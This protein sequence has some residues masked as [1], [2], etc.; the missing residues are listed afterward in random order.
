MDRDADRIWEL[1][2]IRAFW[3]EAGPEDL[4]EIHRK[5]RLVLA[6]ERE[7]FAGLWTGDRAVLAPGHRFLA[8]HPE[9]RHGVIVSLHQG[10]YKLIPELYLNEGISP[11][12]LVNNLALEK[13]RPDFEV[14]AD[15][16]G[17]KTPITWI[18]VG[19]PRFAM[20]LLKEA[21][22]NRPIIVYFDGNSGGD[23]FSE[24][25]DQ[26]L[27]YQL[28]GREVR[29]RTGLARLVCRLGLAV[30]ML[31]VYWDEA[32]RPVWTKERS[33]RW[34]RTADPDTVTRLMADWIFSQVQARPEQ[35]HFWMML[36]ESCAC[37]ANSHLAGPQVPEGLRNDYQSA[38]VTCCER[39][40]ETVRLILQSEAEVWPGGVLADLTDDRFFD[41]AGLRDE[42]LETLRSG[43]LSL[44]E[45]ENIHG[46]A[47][48]RFHGLR[49]CLLGMARL[50]G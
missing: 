38:F 46:R 48:V 42:D 15:R 50:G 20:K 34:D 14:M 12:V 30:H 22:A 11:V 26:G 31:G 36:K 41:S 17:L 23:G 19:E 29:I 32:F 39:S 9:L 40:P 45:L 49:L 25:R 44:A 6:K 24:T 35:W 2:N 47:W 16:L 33:Q 8:D 5:R 3:P 21:K 28:A 7:A 13:M 37:F 1:W 18:A 4:E 43:E 10:P 27:P